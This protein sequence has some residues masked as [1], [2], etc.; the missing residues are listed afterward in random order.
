MQSD[1]RAARPPI[2]LKDRVA[3]PLLRLAKVPEHPVF[4]LKGGSSTGKSTAGKAA[5]SV[6]AHPDVIISWGSSE[7]GL[8]EA[9]ADCNDCALV[10]DAAEKASPKRRRELLN[11]IVHTVPGG[12]IGQPSAAIARR[13]Q[14]PGGLFRSDPFW[15]KQM[16]ET[17]LV[18]E[19]P[20]ER[21]VLLCGHP[22]AAGPLSAKNGSFGFAPTRWLS[23]TWMSSRWCSGRAVARLQE[24]RATRSGRPT[25][26]AA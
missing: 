6:I 7:R 1:R 13:H 23:A 10:L 3:G 16:A 9:P 20:A 11:R 19:N 22:K 24:S 2:A 25:L 21:P 12:A 8:E 18:R 5:A 4:N 26:M 17:S 15:M 14:A